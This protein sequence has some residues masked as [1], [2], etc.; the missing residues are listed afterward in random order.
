[1]LLLFS[2]L[3]HLHVNAQIPK[4]WFM[5]PDDSAVDI[6]GLLNS[7]VGFL[8][9]PIIITEPALDFGGG[10]ALAYFHDT[11]G[12]EK[13]QKGSLPPIISLGAGAYTA[14][15]SWLAALGHQGSYLNDRI[16][17]LGA[18]AY[19]SVNLGFYGAG[20]L[21]EERYDF[22]M[23]GFMT[24]HEL[25]FKINKGIPIFTGLN[26]IF[27]NNNVTFETGINSP[28]LETLEEENNL[29]GM[30]FVAVWDS[31]DNMLTPTKG[32][33]SAFEIGRFDKKLGGDRNYRN[34]SNRTYAYL[35]VVQEKLFSGWRLNVAAK[36]GDVPFYELPFISL[37]GVPLMRYQDNNVLVG[38]TEWRWN[39]FR[40]WSLV[41]FTGLG[42]VAPQ[43]KDIELDDGIWA[44][45]AGFRYFL[46]KDFGIH[47]GIDIAK[48]PEIW[49]WYLTIGSHWFR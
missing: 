15:K 44:G 10:L 16:R 39:L 28:D 6:S 18:V 27:F 17:Y 20:I 34:F 3:F 2:P 36:W 37:R 38:E 24:F 41:G 25:L 12:A 1:M 46:A 43:L 5:H 47:A 32:I 31:R 22:N 19:I 30:N 49:A 23:K 42:Y 14:N 4:E 21:T 13:G 33:M 9:V 29:G 26:Y 40:R 11:K 45:G 7:K 8:P 48:G 35:P